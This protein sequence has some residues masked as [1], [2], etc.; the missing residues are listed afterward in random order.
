[1]EHKKNVSQY[2]N[3]IVAKTGLTRKHSAEPNM[4]ERDRR[5]TFLSA[6]FPF[7]SARLISG[8][9]SIYISQQE[10]QEQQDD[11]TVVALVLIF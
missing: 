4:L 1:M 8:I 6:I 7:I 10:Q 11:S 3:Y 2:L 9:Y 5:L